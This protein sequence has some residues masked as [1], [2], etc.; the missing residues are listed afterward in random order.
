MLPYLLAA[1]VAAAVPTSLDVVAMDYAFR[2]PPR[3]RAGVVSVRLT[4]TGKKLHHLQ[5]FRLTDGKRLG[6]VYP[7]FLK[8]KSIA[9]PPSWAIPAGGPSAA[10]PGKSIAVTT[11][12]EP[13]RYALICWI[14]AG[15]GTLHFMKGMAGEVEVVPPPASSKE[16]NADVVA[17][18]KDFSI[19]F[20]KAITA[21]RHTV[22]VDNRGTHAHEWLVVKLKP[23]MSARDVAE[24]SGAGQ[25]GEPPHSEWFGVAAIPTGSHAYVTHTFTRGDYVAFCLAESKEGVLHLMKGM[26]TRF[27]VR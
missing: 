24:W 4:N 15:D 13:G 23:G 20:S 26:E 8:A 1:Q 16:P 25:L 21:G 18:T 2:V 22:R 17:T 19:A 14:P 3:V 6:D 9:E 5:L 27:S 10:M 11:R 12:L 7:I